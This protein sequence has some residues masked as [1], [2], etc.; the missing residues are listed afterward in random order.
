MWIKKVFT[1]KIFI[2]LITLFLLT[3]AAF[4]AAPYLINVDKQQASIAQKLKENRKLE[5]S[6][7]GLR[8]QTYPDFTYRITADEISLCDES[9]ERLIYI[10]KLNFKSH[11]LPLILKKVDVILMNAD[12][13]ELNAY[14]SKDKK[15]T[16]KNKAF[17]KYLSSFKFK[18]SLDDTD[19]SVK[20]HYI[21]ITE[22][23]SN[24]TLKY[25]GGN[26]KAELKNKEADF[27]THGQLYADD[28][29]SEI[30]LNAKLT[31]PLENILKSKN[32][33]INGTI[34]KL[35]LKNLVHFLPA[36]QSKDLKSLQGGI[37]I[38]IT[39]EAKIE[40]GKKIS[41]L[42]FSALVDN[43][44][45]IRAKHEDSIIAQGANHFKFPMRI[46]NNKLLISNARIEGNDY[47]I[48]V[49]GNIENKNK[50][51]LMNLHIKILDAKAE[52][53]YWLLPSDI[54][55]VTSE[56]MIRALKKYNVTSLATVDLTV[57]GDFKEPEFSGKANLQDLHIGTLPKDSHN[58]NIDL[59]FI[60]KAVKIAAKVYFPSVQ[61]LDVDG[62]TNLY[63]TKDGE[64][65]IKSSENI[66]LETAHK[67][68]VAL[69]EMFSFNIGPLPI[70]ALSGTGNVAMTCGGAFN[71][72][73]LHGFLKFKNAKVALNDLAA[74]LENA[75]G[76][77][78]FKGKI[79]SFQTDTATF[80]NTPV[81]LKGTSSINGDM[82]Y[83]FIA[84]DCPAEGWLNVLKT[85]EILKSTQGAVS[86][87]SSLDGKVGVK[88]K[89]V[90]K[91]K[92]IQHDTKINHLM[93]NI[94]T[95][96]EVKLNGVN[97]KLTSLKAPI[98]GL[99][100][101]IKFENNDF[102]ADLSSKIGTSPVFY[103]GILKGNQLDC[104]VT[105]PEI[106]LT[107]AINFL[108][109]SNIF[110]T[111]QLESQG[112]LNS[113]SKFSLDAKYK[114][115]IDRKNLDKTKFNMND[116][117][118][119]AKFIPTVKND[120]DILRINAGE[121]NLK[122]GNVKLSQI[123]AYLNNAPIKLSGEIQKTF[124][125]SQ[126]INMNLKISDLDMSFLNQADKASLLPEK[127]TKIL[128]FYENYQGKVNIDGSITKN[129]IKG[130]ADII[131]IKFVQKK[132]KLPI[133]LKS[134]TVYMNDNKVTLHAINGLIDA[135]P[136]FLNL[137][138]TNIFGTPS[139]KGYVTTKFNDLFVDSLI[140]PYM[141]Y[142][143]KTK[144]DSTLTLDISGS[145]EKMNLKPTLKLLENADI[146]FMG[147]NL[148]DTDH[149]REL[150]ADVNV[151][152][153][154]IEIRN[155]SLSRYVSSQNS[156]KYA[157]KFINAKGKLQR[158][159]NGPVVRQFSLKTE[160]PTNAKIFNI[161][162][163]KSII[164]SG[165]FTCDFV[166]NRYF[167][168]PSLN[169]FINFDNVE[170]PT[171]NTNIKDLDFKVDN[172]KITIDAEGKVFDS[173]FTAKSSTENIFNFP[174]KIKNLD[175]FTNSFNM[176]TILNT[177]SMVNLSNKPK[178]LPEDYN[179]KSELGLSNLSAFVVEKGSIA[180]N[181][182]LFKD[183]KASNLRGDF[184]LD[185]NMLLTIR[186]VEFNVAGGS[187]KGDSKYN[188]A[189]GEMGITGTAEGVDANLISETL[190]DIKNQIYGNLS[191]QMDITTKGNTEEER[192]KNTKGK[193]YF[194]IYDGKMP[195]LGSLEYLLRA[196]NLIKSGLW[197]LSINRIIGLLKPFNSGEF[198]KIQ[199]GMTMDKGIAKNLE[200][201][202]KGKDMSIY[203]NGQYD[204]VN[205]NADMQVWGRLSS[206]EG[207]F[208]GPVGNASLNT[209]FKLIPG[210][211]SNEFNIDYAEAIKKIPSIEA[212]PEDYKIFKAKI[213]GDIN[214]DKY[215]TSFN[216][217]KWTEEK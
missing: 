149:V 45:L 102:A 125:K 193:F 70:M 179:S 8:L 67:I 138:I 133:T 68:L 17:A 185:S 153:E 32:F 181:N 53:I 168:A 192:L 137:G 136:V 117:I 106:V 10:E 30:N 62:V 154:T 172:N 189:T 6:G 89:L 171:N 65:K 69:S 50:N 176:N 13:L 94:Q 22:E 5:Y 203:I 33:D 28:M 197:G 64:Y 122:N 217:I 199:G 74:V 166:L 143:V 140:N 131:D 216:W 142:P 85:S 114:T 2:I 135:A 205:E 196:T 92:N 104:S 175:V 49:N 26:F 90:G 12:Y 25:I 113:A 52:A 167:N 1:N 48:D 201:F 124:S 187:L 80:N 24:I 169:G 151:D 47:A 184:S 163:K 105:S 130:K 202:S 144:G 55:G 9:G 7:Q 14:L 116:V 186:N 148:D 206:S 198:V 190:F 15:L 156:D 59:D 34:T 183:L 162:F 173:T 128:D 41:L 56:N 145:P 211:G 152:S 54:P 38:S 126:M 79:F 29:S 178:L 37:D 76:K 150:S 98:E 107:S 91:A 71:N 44:E 111:Q 57:K 209:L 97:A 165:N 16:F 207:T 141:T 182:I 61:T 127:I 72:G 43:F 3:E 129:K 66:N 35:D 96:G 159:P 88:I 81:S 42:I 214:G 11:I 39:S 146:F 158:T 134:G 110:N 180:A 23:T 58:A 93:N 174:I 86:Q 99:S 139:F 208:L 84:E 210:Y 19:I 51:S 147:A 101:N 103:K 191:G 63:G 27:S 115:T 40:S 213:D 119:M 194:Q 215:V 204:V 177:F 123:D 155:M 4:L 100:G 73:E 121:I 195:K 157:V 95:S 78:D 212:S 118:L 112:L 77:V 109:A 108:T 132:N 75:S 161:I 200:I 82:D 188:F 120:K 164:K 160:R 170:I 21:K 60:G 87:I 31:L 36:S 83:E 46:E 20:K 18:I